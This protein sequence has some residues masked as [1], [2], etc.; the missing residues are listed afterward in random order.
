MLI[1]MENDS[2]FFAL[3]HAPFPPCFTHVRDFPEQGTKNC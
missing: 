1:K 3:Y 2:I